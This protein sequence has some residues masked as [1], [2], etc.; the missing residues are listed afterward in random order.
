MAKKDIWKRVAEYAFVAAILAVVVFIYYKVAAEAA[1]IIR[2]NEDKNYTALKEY[3][4]GFGPKGAIIIAT[5]EMLQMIVVFLPAEF[6]QIA[7]GLS[8]PVYFALPICM[9]GVFLGS[10]VIFIIVRCL[11]LR[12]DLLERKTG[13]IQ[14]FVSQINK[15]ASMTVIMYILFVMPLIPFGAIAYFASSSKI[16]YPRY[17]LVCTTGVI[18]SILSSYILGNVMINFIDKGTKSFAIAV[19]LVAVGMVLL[20]VV[21]AYI[22][23]RVFFVKTYQKPNFFLYHIIYFFCNIYFSMKF[24]ISTKRCERK[25]FKKP[26]LILGRHTTFFD[27][28]FVAKTIYPHRPTIVCNRY[29]CEAKSTHRVVRSLGVIP[30]KLFSMDVDTMRQL[31]SAKK[32]LRPIV[33]FP[34]GRLSSDGRTM[35]LNESTAKLVKKLGLDVYVYGTVGG[36]FAKP[37]WRNKTVRHKVDVVLKKLLT[38]EQTQSMDIV[39]INEALDKFFRYDESEN[40]KEL[41]QKCGHA[42]VEGL[43]HILYRCKNCGKDYTLSADK[44]T[45]V[46]S[47]CGS[48]FVFDDNYLL[49]D[50]GTIS[51]WNDEIMSAEKQNKTFFLQ[52]NCEIARFD[53]KK[54]AMVKCGKGVCT[55]TENSITYVGSDGENE[56]AEYTHTHKTLAVLAF[57]CNEEFEFYIDDELLYFYPENS[58]A[59]AK[60]SLVWDLCHERFKNE[61]EQKNGSC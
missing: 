32:Q 57:A 5:L 26:C 56:R 45:L 4:Q 27:F 47:E 60:W 9:F 20:L 11:H 30:K 24:R 21:L 19:S 38:A 17:A 50:G 55:L 10:S 42:D 39:G 49:A 12:M 53:K 48:K 43:Q 41:T 6:V 44:N 7:A 33:I 13:K 16:K 35:G 2:L 51:S 52:E 59:V 34:E 36:Y 54:R 14:K 40:Y 37:K 1:E 29:Y 46:C 8:Y 28:F 58:Q 22:I 23:K 25:G 3:L 31:Y 15:D 61:E 18:P